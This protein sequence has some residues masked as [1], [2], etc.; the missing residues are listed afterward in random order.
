M[1]FKPERFLPTDGRTPEP[2]PHSL[3]FGFGRRI[4][5]G[6]ILADSALFLNVAQ[7]LAVFNIS[8]IMQNGQEVEPIVKFQPGVVS[9]PVPYQTAIKPRSP[10]HEALIRSIETV[11][12]WQE[13]DAKVLESVNYQI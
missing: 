2:D 8:K 5:P 7:S 6:R 4:C 12:P 11:H 1:E 9:H 10:Q 13:S 3:V